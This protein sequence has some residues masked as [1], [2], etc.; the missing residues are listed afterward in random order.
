[1]DLAQVGAHNDEGEPMD[2][3]EGVDSE[4]V[5]RALMEGRQTAAERIGF[6]AKVLF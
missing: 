2:A 5:T 1:M 3:A 4:A 6:L